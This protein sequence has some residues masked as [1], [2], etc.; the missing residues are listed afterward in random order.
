MCGT[1]QSN[2]KENPKI[3]TDKQLKIGEIEG[4]ENS[5]GIEVLK[6]KDKRNVL[7]LTTVSQH[8]DEKWQ[9]S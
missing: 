6:W 1:L 8:T 4:K 7:M 2:R 9:L 5:E 3:V